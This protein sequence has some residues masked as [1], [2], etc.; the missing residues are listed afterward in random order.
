MARGP[1]EEVPAHRP[2]HQP[3]PR[4][5]EQ[6]G[7]RHPPSERGQARPLHRRL[8]RFRTAPGRE[9]AAAGRLAQQAGSRA[10]PS[11]VLRRPL[12]RQ[13][14]QG[15]PGPVAHEDARQA[16]ADRGGHR[17]ACRAFHPALARAAPRAP[18]DAAGE[19]RCGL[20]RPADPARPEP[21]ARHR[22]PH[23]PSGRQRRRQVDLRQDGCRRACGSGRHHAAGRTRQG[24]LVPPAP[25]RG[26][27]SRRHAA[28][29][30]PPR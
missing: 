27:G 30:H 19:R 9:A 21:A 15:D 13:G 4:A 24:R 17:G 8:R 6:F 5:A 12:P 20:W 7:R 2:G 3:R 22:R 18:A 25:D 16:A 14:Q 11:A 10:R 1:A 29:D 23:R 28:G 26:D